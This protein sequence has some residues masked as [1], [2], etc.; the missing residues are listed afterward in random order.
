MTF[1]EDQWDLLMSRRLDGAAADDE[2]L[3]LDREMIRNPELRARW[4][5]LRRIDEWAAEALLGASTEDAGGSTPRQ[6]VDRAVAAPVPRRNWRRRAHRGWVLIPGAIAAALAALMIPRPETER[7]QPHGPV[8][9]QAAQ[10]PSVER[11][12]RR[13]SANPDLMRTVG[14]TRRSRGRDVLGIVGDDGNVYFLEVDRMR[15]V[16]TPPQG[17]TSNE[18]M[19]M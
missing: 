9:T 12:I 19:R 15:T 8:V 7:M 1:N 17:T 4:D 13:A 18:L 14:S 10:R 16:R 3:E 2:I 11:P 5:E 6:I